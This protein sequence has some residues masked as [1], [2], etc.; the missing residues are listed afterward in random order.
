MA[1]GL[2]NYLVKEIESKRHCSRPA[3]GRDRPSA[4]AHFSERHWGWIAAPR[5][6]KMTQAANYEINTPA[7]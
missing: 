2:L 7:V 4:R 5:T 1:G 3:G 6:V